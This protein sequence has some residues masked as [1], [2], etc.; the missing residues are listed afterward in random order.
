MYE[1]T[2][3]KTACRGPTQA[4]WDL[5]AEMGRRHKPT[6]LTQKLSPIDNC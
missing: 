5:N 4:K 3:S 6:A 2:E 1:L